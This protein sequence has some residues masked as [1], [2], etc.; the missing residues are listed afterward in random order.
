[1]L[2]TNSQT[3]VLSWDEISEMV[4]DL[5]MLIP[6]STKCINPIDKESRILALLIAEQMGIDSYESGGMS[7]GVTSV[8]SPDFCLYSYEWDDEEIPKYKG[9]AINAF[10]VPRDERQPKVIPPWKRL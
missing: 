10:F 5:V 1:M 7:V 2:T 4:A 8:G 6:G 9:R 3:V